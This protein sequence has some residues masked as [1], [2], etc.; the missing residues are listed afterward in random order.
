[1]STVGRG[2]PQPTARRAPAPRR[3]AR[4]PSSRRA[5]RV[6]R[7]PLRDRRADG[8]RAARVLHRHRAVRR[9][10]RP[11]PARHGDASTWPSA[12]SLTIAYWRVVVAHADPLLRGAAVRAARD[13]PPRRHRRRPPALAGPVRLHLARARDR[14]AGMARARVNPTTGGAAM[15]R[16]EACP[17]P[18]ANPLVRLALPALTQTSSAAT[19]IPSACTR[20]R[21]ALLIGYGAVR[22]GDRHAAPRRRAAEGA[23]RDEGGGARQLRVLQRHRLGASRARRASARRSCSLCRATATAASSSELE[24]L[25]LDYAT[26]M[27]RTPT[28]RRPTSCS[29]PC[30][31]TS[32]SASSSS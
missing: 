29:R 24:K 10:E 8:L 4:R 17:S 14:R 31:S 27:S 16:I 28:T 19:S 7:L 21:P 23:R 22:E 25:V 1:M 13:Q 9:A 2:R 26:A 20:T 11:L 5:D 18:Q 32:T 6:R 3:T 30:A 15:T 12:S